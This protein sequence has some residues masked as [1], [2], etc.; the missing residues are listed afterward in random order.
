MSTWVKNKSSI[1][2]MSGEVKI[3]KHFDSLQLLNN[4]NNDNDLFRYGFMCI[5]ANV[6]S[7]F[8]SGIFSFRCWMY[9]YILALL[10]TLSKKIQSELIC[11]WVTSVCKTK[12]NEWKKGNSISMC[13]HILNNV[14]SLLWHCFAVYSLIWLTW[15]KYTLKLSYHCFHSRRT[16][17]N[18]AQ[19]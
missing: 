6:L 2:I 12:I 15:Q 14:S 7:E 5:L 1:G 11:K 3:N 18:R 17:N 13:P 10:F 8:F 19:A 16:Y 9:P 4:R